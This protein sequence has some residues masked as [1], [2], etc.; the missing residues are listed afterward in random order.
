MARDRF[1]DTYNREAREEQNRY[2]R[3]HTEDIEECRPTLLNTKTH[4]EMN[5]LYKDDCKRQVKERL[6]EEFDSL[7]DNPEISKENKDW[8]IQMV[9]SILT[10]VQ[11]MK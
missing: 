7:Y 11:Q 6:I 8:A 2:R 1:D 4:A 5:K 10:K 9:F 3:V